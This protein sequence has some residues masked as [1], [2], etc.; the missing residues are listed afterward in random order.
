MRVEISMT[1]KKILEAIKILTQKRKQ[2]KKVQINA[3]SI[4][5]EACLDWK[6]TNK[7]LLKGVI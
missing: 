5:K 3:Y 6:T 2:D 1:Q 4:S 7:Y